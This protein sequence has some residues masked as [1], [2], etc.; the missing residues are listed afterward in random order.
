MIETGSASKVEHAG[1]DVGVGVVVVAVEPGVAVVVVGIALEV[2]VVAVGVGLGDV[3]GVGLCVGVSLVSVV[4]TAV[5]DCVSTDSVV[6]GTAVSSV[7]AV[8]RAPVVPLPVV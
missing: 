4:A 7:C 3:V 6:D 1:C 2:D 5:G 8:V